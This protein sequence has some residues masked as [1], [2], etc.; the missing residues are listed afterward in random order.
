M[1]QE[2]ASDT[3]LPGGLDASTAV[4]LLAAIE[5]GAQMGYWWRDTDSGQVHC[6]A[7][8]NRLFGCEPRPSV[9]DGLDQLLEKV[10]AE[11]HPHAE[12]A[13]EAASGADGTSTFDL[14]CRCGRADGELRYLRHRGLMQCSLGDGI[15]AQVVTVQDVTERL[16]AESTNRRLGRILE[17][18]YN[19]IFVIDQHTLRFVQ[20][21]RGAR[22]NLGYSVEE[23]SQMTPVDIS[24]RLTS[25]QDFKR[26]AAS[27]DDGEQRLLTYESLQIRKDGSTYPVEVRLSLSQNEPEPVYV[28]VVED[29]TE[30]KQNERIRDEFISVVSHELRTPLTPISGVLELLRKT[31]EIQG[32]ENTSK[33]VDIAHRNAVRLRRLIEQLLDFR[34][35]SLGDASFDMRNLELRD[36]VKQ[37]IQNLSY[38]DQRYEFEL[39][40]DLGG[41]ELWV[42]ADRR[43]VVQLIN[44]LLS[45][46]AKFSPP[47]SI[48]SVSAKQVGKCARLSVADQGPGIPEKVREH[49]FDRFVQADSTSTRHHGGTGLG[50]SLAKLIVDS[51]GGDISFECGQEAGTT[52]NVDLPL[53]EHVFD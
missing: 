40:V 24:T 30:R 51:F 50:L 10:C 35:L 4:T 39:D 6:S 27:L 45:N 53:R 2:R 49:I 20:V 5:Q 42:W 36:V 17:D 41:A 19:E 1:T 12:Q 47:R 21:N 34:N 8:L 11:D 3:P 13:L 52:F 37:T 22:L 15:D 29:I 48:I 43:Y 14:T 7:G 16:R 32:N 38:L 9:H 46:A 25:A 31:P 26:R 23:M 18:S 44:I 33:M 28:A